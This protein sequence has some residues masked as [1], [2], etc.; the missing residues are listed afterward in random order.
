M[1]QCNA[2]DYALVNCS[3]TFRRPVT[4][5]VICGRQHRAAHVKVCHCEGCVAIV[6]ANSKRENKTSL[7]LKSQRS[8]LSN[9]C[10]ILTQQHGIFVKQG[11]ERYE[12]VIL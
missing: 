1:S 4:I 2:R 6:A 5:L 12:E 8:P 9:I 3:G 7:V 10:L 11:L